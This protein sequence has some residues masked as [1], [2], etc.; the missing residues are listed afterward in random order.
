MHDEIRT[1]EKRSAPRRQVDM[2]ALLRVSELLHGRGHIKNISR[3]GIL[4]HT[5]NLFANLRNDRI[6]ARLGSPIKVVF[7]GY[8]VTAYGKIV[9]INPKRG[10][11]AIVL[12]D[13]SDR[14][15]WESMCAQ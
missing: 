2:V 4:L 3:N 9:R 15:A 5:F 14:K 6:P 13:T 7:S 1:M 8:P 12:K 11:V 10:E